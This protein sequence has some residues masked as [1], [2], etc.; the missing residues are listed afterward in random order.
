MLKI[1]DDLVRM[2][3]DKHF[4]IQMMLART[5]LAMHPTHEMNL[6]SVKVRSYDLGFGP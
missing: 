3:V 6:E 4:G 2:V 1:R 5:I